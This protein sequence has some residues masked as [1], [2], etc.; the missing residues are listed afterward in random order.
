[1]P[2]QP[3]PRPEAFSLTTV[4]GGPAAGDI[5]CRL[6]DIADGKAK[7]FTYKKGTWRLEVFIQRRGDEFFAYENTCPHVGLPLN[8]APNKFLNRDGTA[9]FCMNHAADFRIEDGLCTAGP[10]LGKWLI[11][12]ALRLEDGNIIVE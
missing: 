7:T 9:L 3:D 4:D 8:L 2:R 12:V 5:L 11:P 6:N 1:M 10:C